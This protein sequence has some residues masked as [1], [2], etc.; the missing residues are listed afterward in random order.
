MKVKKQWH[1]KDIKVT[2][3]LHIEI[4]LRLLFS[5]KSSARRSPSQNHAIRSGTHLNT[6]PGVY[7]VTERTMSN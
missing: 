5:Q 6:T 7:G 2:L 3:R 1:K 4:S